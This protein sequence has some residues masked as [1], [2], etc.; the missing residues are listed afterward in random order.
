MKKAILYLIAI[1]S[2]SCEIENIDPLAPIMVTD[3]PTNIQANSAVL[4][5]FVLGEG[6][7]AI[8]EYGLVLGLSNPPT[9]QDVKIQV[10]TGIGFFSDTYDIL[11]PSTTYYYSTYGI[12][13]VGIGYGQVFQFTTDP[14]PSCDPQQE[15]SINTGF[16]TISI[17]TVSLDDPSGFNDGNLEF[18]T[19]TFSSTLRIKVR[20]NEIDANLPLTGA[21]TTV[22]SYDNQ[23]IRSN[24]EVIILI[25]DFGIG[26]QGG[27]TS[28]IDE[29][30]FIEND[31]N[32]VT[33]IFC[34]L[35]VGSVYN[36]NGKFSY[37]N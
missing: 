12:N 37:P 26:S 5:G 4:G 31:G 33:F 21:Y 14:A 24:G 15:N 27:G 13:E 17:N 35:S 10:G 28:P 30:L 8:T 23:S 20:F 16:G 7:K 2:I 22:N 6:G 1:I 19:S 18:E 36:L 3:E 11:T 9:V 25:E 34:D 32:T 29:T